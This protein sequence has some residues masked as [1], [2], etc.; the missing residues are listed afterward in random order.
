MPHR[1]AAWTLIEERLRDACVFAESLQKD[2]DSVLS[3]RLA[4][5]AQALDESADSLAGQLDDWGAVSR[6][7][8][9]RQASAATPADVALLLDRAAELASTIGA[10]LDQERSAPREL[11]D[12]AHTLLEVVDEARR[13]NRR[14]RGLARE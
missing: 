9:G 6:Y 2:S 10:A 12:G 7:A 1:E 13:R 11:F 3:E 8:G 14:D 4:P 5:V